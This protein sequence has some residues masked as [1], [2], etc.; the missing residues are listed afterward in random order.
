MLGTQHFVL[1][2]KVVWFMILESFRLSFVQ[3]FVLFRSVLYFV[4]WGH[5]ICIVAGFHFFGGVVTTE[6][7]GGYCGLDGK[8]LLSL[9]SYIC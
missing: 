9:P 6:N 5:R 3:R 2:L 1:C 7:T 8:Q 4:V